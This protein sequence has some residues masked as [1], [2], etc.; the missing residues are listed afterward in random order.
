MGPF[1]R[2]RG[3]KKTRKPMFS[4]RFGPWEV[5]KRKKTLY[6]TMVSEHTPVTTKALRTAVCRVLRSGGPSA[7]RP[8]PQNTRDSW[9]QSGRVLG[10][11]VG[12][13]E[14][15]QRVPGEA[16]EPPRERKTR[17]TAGIFKTLLKTSFLKMCTPLECQAHFG[18]KGSRTERQSRRTAVFFVVALKV[19][20]GSQKSERAHQG[21]F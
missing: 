18:Q 17:Q 5:P 7:A 1:W 6:F 9:S 20:R 12:P 8:Q 10:L 2:R 14:L 19:A 3:T 15:P 4:C 13:P 16:Q 11:V 21:V